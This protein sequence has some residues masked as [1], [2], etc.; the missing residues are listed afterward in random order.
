MAVLASITLLPAILG[1]V[2]DHI[3]RLR[4]PAPPHA[5]DDHHPHGW[6]RW[7]RFVAR[8]P[9]PCALVALVVLIA[10]ALPTLDLYL[11]QQ[12]NGALP[13]STEARQSYDG[14]TSSFGVGANGP[15]LV[16]VDMSKQP[17]K[18]DQSKLD[19]LNKQ[20]SDQKAQA[21]QQAQAQIASLEAQGVPPDQAQ[22]QVQ[23]QLDK[24]LKQISDKASTQRKQ[25]DQN[26]TDPRLSK[27]RTDIE[28]ASG[29]K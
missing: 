4:A 24:Q 16:S 17:A 25:L 14:M 22:A 13:K 2:G 7:A 3:D 10:L 19:Q 23:P 1:M 20:E 9:L 18:P 21:N 5:E 29:V 15:L 26:A 27:L 6:A 12:D 28:H 11:G 8:R